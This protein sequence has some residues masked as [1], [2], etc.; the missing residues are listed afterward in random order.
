[1]R[2]VL[3][4]F[5][6]M[7]D[8]Q[9]MMA[10]AV[11]LRK[12]GH[13][14]VLALSPTFERR[15]LEIGIEFVPTGPSLSLE[16]IRGVIS[17]QIQDVK[18]AD[19]VRHFLE[20]ML[21]LVPGMYESLLLTCLGA[22]VLVG[23]PYQ[24]ACQMVHEKTGIHYV[25]LHLSQFGYLG[26]KDIREV[27]SSL[28]NA[29]RVRQGFVP[30]HDPLGADG[31][32]RELAI[33][34]V[35]SHFLQRPP[36]WPD[37]YKVV[38]FLFLDEPTT[39]RQ[40]EWLESGT[41][42]LPIVI[43]FGSVVH[44]NR[45]FIEK[46]IFDAVRQI[47]R[48]VI[49]Q[50]GWEG[51]GGGLLP[52]N[53]VVV[54]YVPHS[55]LFPRASL[56]VHHGGAGTTASALR[57]GVPTVVVPH[58]LDQPIWAEFVRSRGCARNVIPFAQLNSA[59]LAAAIKGTLNSPQAYVAAAALGAQISSEKGVETAAS[60]IE[61]LV[62]RRASDTGQG[63]SARKVLRQPIL[64]TVSATRSLDL[65]DRGEELPLSF[66]QHRLWFLHQ[67]EPTSVTYNVASSMRLNGPLDCMALQLSVNELLRRHEV[68]R[69]R[70]PAVGGKPVQ[71]VSPVAELKLEQVDLSAM[72]EE[73]RERESRNLLRR[74]AE[75][76]FDLECGPTVRIRLLRL[77]EQ[78][79][80]LLVT[81]HHIVGDAWSMDIMTK[82]LC[83][84]YEAY[85]HGEQPALDD[86]TIQYTEFAKWQR[87]SLKAETLSEHLKYWREQLSGISMRQMLT[88]TPRSGTMSR[89]SAVA[90]FR[91]SPDLSRRA[92][93]FSRR[94]GATLFM[95]LL[96]VLEIVL[97]TYA[98]T[99]D[100]VV[101]TAIAN[102][103]R[104][105]TEGLIGFLA[106]TLVLRTNLSDDPSF[107]EL[108]K[109]VKNVC[110]G[111]YAHQDVPFDKLVE[112]LNPK[113]D[114]SRSPLFQIMF[115]LQRIETDYLQAGGLRI[116]EFR[117][118]YAESMFDI[119]FQ[120]LEGPAGI[121]AEV[122]YVR[123]LYQEETI[124]MMI[125]HFQ[126][127]LEDVVANPD[128]RLSELHLLA[129]GDRRGILTECDT[130]TTN[131]STRARLAVDGG[132]AEEERPYE[133]PRSDLQQLLATI[134]SNLLNVKKVSLSDNFFALGGQSLAAIRAV[135]L[136][137][138]ILGIPLS[139][140]DLFEA[141]TLSQFAQLMISRDVWP[142]QSENAARTVRVV[143]AMNPSEVRKALA[144][145]ESQ[146]ET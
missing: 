124:K 37:H 34:A 33:Y 70:F 65:S 58:T 90:R 12:M 106:N 135:S 60:L 125:E 142:G 128:H 123:D 16:A 104:K 80:I 132:Y 99:D 96:A 92:K 31:N 76:P 4:T 27:S 103:T 84:M 56:V 2:V 8:I 3:S 107:T 102:R 45:E 18:P 101:G 69:T 93:E 41:P 38:G 35:S 54:G 85:S 7:G 89:K 138:T 46:L 19:Q 97:H 77:D 21:P 15:A 131:D 121:S 145:S 14:A 61:E 141:P 112:E 9:P 32:S 6:S 129:A 86:P 53:V 115:L 137:Q 83:Q 42:E 120:L 91:L 50:Q 73:D 39:E 117:Y 24:F 75:K 40:P 44:S 126:R 48:K 116:G 111:A 105:E 94:E 26:G 28:I 64:Q 134:W 139:L 62:S 30:L 20:G 59:R 140:R 36:R 57:A 23:S 63:A 78:N 146:A 68:L 29:C 71:L 22:D 119:T 133:E 43:T 5:G 67:V 72:G 98:M 122:I 114:R 144:K 49:L 51:L 143:Q 109:R 17:S 55:W 118:E 136:I 81:M 88:D 47:N 25:S 127:V 1:M 74:E 13:Q 66:S 79:H 113:R 10:L 100:L 82:E 11:Q 87:E 52:D 95:M 130:A 110:V 108:L